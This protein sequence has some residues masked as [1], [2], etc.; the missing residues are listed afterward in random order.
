MHSIRQLQVAPCVQEPTA[1]YIVAFRHPDAIA[2]KFEQFS[3]SVAKLVPSL[4]FSRSDVH[5]TITVYEK[6][7]LAT[8]NVN[9]E[10]LNQL[11]AACHRIDPSSLQA[12]HIEYSEWL[13]NSEAVIAAG[14]PNDAFWTV[15]EN[16]REV[17]KQYGLDWRMPW[18]GHVTVGR[19]LADSNKVNELRAL[20]TKHAPKLG[21]SKPVAV[22]VGSYECSESGFR[23]FTKS[24]RYI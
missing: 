6:Q 10:I 19:Y 17:G 4:Q 23:L 24:L 14:H 8:F 20:V 16:L 21:H 5:T 2:R 3:A 22:I 11:E 1:G 13:F 7:P 18:G 9:S 12:V 15:G